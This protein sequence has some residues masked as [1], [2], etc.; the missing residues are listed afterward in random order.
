[1]IPQHHVK[2]PDW[3]VFN[4]VIMFCLSV[5]VC[6]CCNQSLDLFFFP[7][8][9]IFNRV[10]HDHKS[11]LQH[12]VCVCVWVA[13]CVCSVWCRGDVDYATSGVDLFSLHSFLNSS[14]SH[15]AAEEN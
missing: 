4:H 15:R 14:V 1:M 7:A 9:F 5:D 13:V 2:A 8:S 11:T 12:S 10:H 6:V 3:C